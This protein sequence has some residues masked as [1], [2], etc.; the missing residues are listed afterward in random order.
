MNPLRIHQ[1][2][3]AAQIAAD[4]AAINALNVLAAWVNQR[5]FGNLATEMLDTFGEAPEAETGPDLFTASPAVAAP[6]PP[7]PALD[8]TLMQGEK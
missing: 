6:K 3:A 4:A 1:P 8:D 5:G 7:P 2:E